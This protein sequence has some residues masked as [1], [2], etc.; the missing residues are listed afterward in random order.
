LVL[1]KQKDMFKQVPKDS[2]ARGGKFIK[3]GTK[4]EQKK[5]DN[6]GF[7]D[8]EAVKD[9][10]KVPGSKSTVVPKGKPTDKELGSKLEIEKRFGKVPAKGAGKVAIKKRK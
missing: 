9:K 2:P 7:I 10:K 3:A 5:V 1:K 6:K 4:V 8:T